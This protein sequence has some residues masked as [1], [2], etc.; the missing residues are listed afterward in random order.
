MTARTSCPILVVDDNAADVELAT[1]A[2]ETDDFPAAITS[3]RDGGE[4]IDLLR[5]ALAEHER[6]PALILLDI[7]MPRFDGYDVLRFLR[8]QPEV[9]R[10]PVV[11]LTTSNS[12]RDRARCE[13]AGA[14]RYL[15]KPRH[16]A[17]FVDLI[18]DLRPLVGL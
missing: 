11:M 9:S 7:N 5:R 1:M 8:S 6:L 10:I 12:P 13:Q 2:F 17:D 4:A 3:A 18:H 14:S 16:F 15:V